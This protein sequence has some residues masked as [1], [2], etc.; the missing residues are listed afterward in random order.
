MLFIEMNVVSFGIYV[1]YIV[2]TALQTFKCG[3]HFTALP[4][5]VHWK[6]SNYWKRI[7]KHCVV[8]FNT[9]I[10]WT[11]CDICMGITPHVTAR[12][13]TLFD[14]YKP[15]KNFL[16]DRILAT[17]FRDKYTSVGVYRNL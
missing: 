11:F 3:R 9:K 15:K 1:E 14:C 2:A 12:L 4:L 10:C 8:Y 16:N 5:N 13:G 7:S 17:S 6:A